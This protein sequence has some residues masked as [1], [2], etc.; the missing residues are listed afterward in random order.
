MAEP[1]LMSIQ[2]EHT[3]A[4]ACLHALAEMWGLRK[5]LDAGGDAKHRQLVL[6]MRFALHQTTL[7]S[8]L[9]AGKELVQ[10]GACSRA[11]HA[12]LPKAPAFKSVQ[13]CQYSS[14]MR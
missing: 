9:H 7:E 14:A 8:E 11:D 3:I 12:L 6:D 1:E 10:A 13:C 4:D 2:L 5:H